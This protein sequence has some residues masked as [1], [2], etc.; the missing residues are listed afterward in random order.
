MSLEFE[1]CPTCAS[2]PGSPALC[3]SCLH[4][5][6]AISQ[7]HTRTVELREQIERGHTALTTALYI[8]GKR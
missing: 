1:E 8:L 2:K 3:P 4:N 6:H 7:L 5:R